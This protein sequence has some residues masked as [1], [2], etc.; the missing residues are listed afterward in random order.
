MPSTRRSRWRG[1]RYRVFGEGSLCGIMQE[2]LFPTFP[3]AIA[4][5][6]EASCIA[7]T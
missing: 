5:L 3:H 1:G 4:Q 2:L 6:V 7:G